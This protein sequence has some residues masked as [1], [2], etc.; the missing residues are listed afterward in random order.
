[1]DFLQASEK[2]NSVGLLR[3]IILMDEKNRLDFFDYVDKYKL[4][5]CAIL[6]QHEGLFQIS[7]CFVFDCSSLYKSII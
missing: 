7:S 4:S 3:K 6:R 5:Q 1:M 2:S